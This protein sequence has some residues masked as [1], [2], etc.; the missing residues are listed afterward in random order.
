MSYILNQNSWTDFK[1]FINSKAISIQYNESDEYYYLSAF[2]SGLVYT[3]KLAKEVTPT[4]DQADF[5]DNYKSSSNLKISPDTVEENGVKKLRVKAAIGVTSS[6]QIMGWDHTP[7]GYVTLG[8][9]ITTDDWVKITIDGYDSQYT[10]EAGDSF[11]DAVSGLV[12]AI[13]ANDNVNTKITASAQYN[14][15]FIRG[16]EA[17]EKYEG[18]T[19]LAAVSSGA[20][21][22]AVR[23]SATLI[24]L[25]KHI[26]VEEDECDRRYGRIGVFGEVGSRKKA[27]NNSEKNH[28][29]YKR[30]SFF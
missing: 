24:M 8:G 18:I 21:L 4:S 17:G 23:S 30:N 27:E 2:D 15:V 9:T 14:R 3:Y 20:T 16:N 22:T 5:E 12:V 6:G 29:V 28:C 7:T 25:W 13:N 10:I 19:L 11:D 1:N 26:L